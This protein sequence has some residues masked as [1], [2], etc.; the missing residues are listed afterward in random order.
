MIILWF[1]RRRLMK[2][3]KVYNKTVR[4]IF[5]RANKGAQVYSDYFSSVCTYMYARSLLSGVILKHDSDYTEGKMQKAHLT[6]L[7]KEI[8]QGRL[9]CSLYEVPVT[10]FS[11]INAFVDITEDFLPEMP[12]DSQLY[13]LIPYKTKNTLELDNTGVTIDAPYSFIM[14]IPNMK[15]LCLFVL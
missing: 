1:L 11:M 6:T 4:N 2:K 15:S 12:S 8:E 9:L 3:I 5:D 10:E 7:E 13:E 14:G